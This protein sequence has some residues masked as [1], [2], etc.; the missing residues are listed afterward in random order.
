MAVRAEQN[1]VGYAMALLKPTPLKS[2]WS[3]Y[4]QQNHD[5]VLNCKRGL[6]L[7]AN[8]KGILASWIADQITHGKTVEQLISETH[9]SWF[10]RMLD[11]GHRPLERAYGRLCCIDDLSREWNQPYYVAHP[12]ESGL[13]ETTDV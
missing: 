4:L 6:F 5:A 13:F 10:G 3:G 11:G 2:N 1:A 7:I 8:T 12:E 9:P